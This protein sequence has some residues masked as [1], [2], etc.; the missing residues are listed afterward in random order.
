MAGKSTILRST[1]AVAVLAACGLFAPV[2]KATVPFTDAFM[3]RTFSADNPKE[4]MSAFRVE[5]NEIKYAPSAPSSLQGLSAF[6]QDRV[7]SVLEICFTIELHL[8]GDI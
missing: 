6:C 7:R 3:L 4:G 5:M 2:E 1:C 8:A